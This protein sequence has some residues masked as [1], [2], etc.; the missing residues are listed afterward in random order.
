MKFPPDKVQQK[1][2]L[3]LKYIKFRNSK[4]FF[5]LTEMRLYTTMEYDCHIFWK[6]LVFQMKN[7]VFQLKY[8]VVYT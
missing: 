3:L 6:Y 7:L 8:R 4:S 5:I 2:A 1:E